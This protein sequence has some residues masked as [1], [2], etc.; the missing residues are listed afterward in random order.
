MK[1]PKIFSRYLYMH[2][3]PV[4]EYLEV[5]D[6]IIIKRAIHA[7]GGVGRIYNH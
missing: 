6:G 5:D 1:Y 3:K 2:S 7:L 4:H